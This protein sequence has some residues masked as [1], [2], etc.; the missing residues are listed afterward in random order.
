[1]PYY[2]YH[3]DECGFDFELRKSMSEC[4]EPTK[5]PCPSCERFGK[6]IK[7]ICAPAIVDSI[8]IG[9]TKPDTAFQKYVLG[10]IQSSVPGNKIGQGKLGPIAREI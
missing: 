2:D 9:V 4:D 6:V 7:A 3:C 8:R 1:M 5:E 10:R